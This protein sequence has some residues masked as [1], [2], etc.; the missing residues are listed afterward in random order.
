MSKK[1]QFKIKK[2]YLIIGIIVFVFIFGSFFYPFLKDDIRNS[3]NIGIMANTID[4][5]DWIY[6]EYS[7]DAEGITISSQKRAIEVFSND[8]NYGLSTLFIKTG[9]ITA[10]PSIILNDNTIPNYVNCWY[11]AKE[12]KHKDSIPYPQDTWACIFDPKGIGENKKYMPIITYNV[13]YIYPE[14]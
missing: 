4:F 1:N 11:Y 13:E 6:Y 10:N 7:A 2:S 8:Y 5:S 3:H 12:I 14:L 9:I